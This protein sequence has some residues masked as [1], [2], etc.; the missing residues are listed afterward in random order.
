MS[1]SKKAV[2]VT[3]CSSGIGLCAANGLRD[4]GYRVFAT[5]RKAADVDRLEALGH[6]SLRLDLN[7]SAS[8]SQAVAQVA[9]RTRG[10]L[11]GLFNN[12]AYGQPGAVEDLSRQALREQFETNVFGT[13]E[14]TRACIKIM[15]AN[16]QGRIVQNSSVLG[17]VALK[18]RGAYNASK[19]ALEGLTDT[20]RL[21][22][23]GSGIHVCLI[24]PGP[25][26]SKFR[27]NAML[28]YRRH[29][30]VE[31]SVFRATYAG[32]ER[33]LRKPGPSSRFTLPSEAVVV[34]LYHALESD[35]P[36]VRYYVT[37][38]TYL[39]AALRRV[40]PYK[41]LDGILATASDRENPNPGE[42]QP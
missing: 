29:I 32:M 15:R 5:A 42:E 39:F 36:R 3:G 11:F 22:L 24:E 12:G 27:D 2:L 18:Y 23:R 33:R 35:R 37:F 14:L 26:V 6:E 7:D 8:I 16:G 40:L 10:R 19:F 20:L 34:K 13:H 1:E 25:I 21:E 38:P 28:A 41:G 30:D 31:S 4:R 9:E 17:L